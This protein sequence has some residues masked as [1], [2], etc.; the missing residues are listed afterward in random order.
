MSCG[1]IYGYARVSSNGRASW[2]T[3]GERGRERVFVAC[4]LL[5]LGF[6][7]VGNRAGWGEGGGGDAPALDLFL[8]LHSRIDELRGG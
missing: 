7:A 5:C 4:V 8:A 2:V 3:F 6:Y 1:I